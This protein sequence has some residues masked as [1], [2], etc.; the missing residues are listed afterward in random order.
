MPFLFIQ[1]QFL[2]RARKSR[3]QRE[4]RERE[5]PSGTVLRIEEAV[6]KD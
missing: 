3:A 1:Q 6:D 5:L 2:T 4:E